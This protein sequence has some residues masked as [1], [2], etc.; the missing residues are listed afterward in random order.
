MWR[1]T[2]RVFS[3]SLSSSSIIDSTET[4][5]KPLP[6]QNDNKKIMVGVGVA[7]VKDGCVL[8]GKRKNS[9]GGGTFAFPGGKL[10]YGETFEQCAV[11]EVMEETQLAITCTNTAAATLEMFLPNEQIHCIVRVVEA[12]IDTSAPVLQQ[13]PVVTE[14]DKCEVRC[15][16][17][18]LFLYIYACYTL[19]YSTRH[20]IIVMMNIFLIKL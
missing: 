16:Y 17:S 8:I 4:V 2:L 14:P 6:K 18:T 15:D 12:K 5:N 7:I 3:K 20:L 13:V 11:R 19:L 9:H 1:N 10:E